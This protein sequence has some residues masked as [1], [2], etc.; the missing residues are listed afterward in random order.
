[1]GERN[2]GDF[3]RTH[4]ADA[5]LA[6]PRGSIPHP[7]VEIALWQMHSDQGVDL[8]PAVD[9]R[10][11]L[12]GRAVE[13]SPQTACHRAAI[14]ESDTQVQTL[15]L[16]FPCGVAERQSGLREAD[17]RG[18]GNFTVDRGGAASVRYQAKLCLRVGRRARS[19]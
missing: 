11:C 7:G 1:M 14:R 13:S 16:F 3:Q 5:L 17:G 4:H 10:E 19:R 8:V 2:A 18:A 15:A 9:R 6:Q 12:I